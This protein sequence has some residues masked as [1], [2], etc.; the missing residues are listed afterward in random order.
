MRNLL[1]TFAVLL[2]SKA[3]LLQCLLM[4]QLKYELV[5]YYNGEQIWIE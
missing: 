4:A 1:G 3:T 5:R 2:K